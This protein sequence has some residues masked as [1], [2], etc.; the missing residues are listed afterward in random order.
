ML[1]TATSPEL[2]TAY[3]ALRQQLRSFLRRHVSDASVADDLLQ[4]IFVKALQSHR[5]GKTI[6][7][8]TAWLYTA[9][10]TTVIDHYRAQAEPHVELDESHWI[11]EENELELH[12]KLA[13][14]LRPFAE[15]LAPIYRDSLLASELDG[16]GMRELAE[17]EGV[18]LSAI[19]SR[20]SRARRMLKDKVLECCHV[21]M[22]DGVVSDYFRH[23]VPPCEKGC[24]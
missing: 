20:V 4:D 19:K 24:G 11:S 5:S 2:G 17:R 13:L 16:I 1:A 22:Q 12:S 18:S 3:L 9:A 21:E 23:P 15:Q 7:N 10:R 6:A 14:C 8:V